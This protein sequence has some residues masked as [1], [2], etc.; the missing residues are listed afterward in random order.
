MIYYYFVYLLSQ[1]FQALKIRIIKGKPLKFE[2]YSSASRQ[3]YFRKFLI[4]RD[5][6]FSL[7]NF[8]VHM[9]FHV[10]IIYILLKSLFLASVFLQIMRS[11]K[12]FM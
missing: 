8:N 1:P 12:M 3:I 5:F 2:I 4:L 7:P 11:F 9:Y 6:V 10:R